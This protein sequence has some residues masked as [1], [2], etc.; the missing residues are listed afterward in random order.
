MAQDASTDVFIIVSLSDDRM[1]FSCIIQC[2]NCNKRL[3]LAQLDISGNRTLWHRKDT[4]V[5]RSSLDLFET[6][7][8]FCTIMWSF[9]RSLSFNFSKYVTWNRLFCAA[10]ET[11]TD[12]SSVKSSILYRM[13]VSWCNVTL[14][15]PMN[16]ISMPI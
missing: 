8:S 4:L 14:T 3:S 1:R 15:S 7:S 2:I 12:T 5:C 6:N 9:I 10:E 16:S 13:C 11:T